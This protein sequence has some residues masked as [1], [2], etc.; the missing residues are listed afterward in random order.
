[1]AAT[2]RNDACPGCSSKLR[3]IRTQDAASHL[4]GG[5]GGEKLVHLVAEALV[6]GP[7]AVEEGA[8][9]HEAADDGVVR[10]GASLCLEQE[11]EDQ[12]DAVVQQQQVLGL[13]IGD[14][15][16]CRQL[17]RPHLLQPP[18]LNL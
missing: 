16:R 9:L 2:C 11:V 15:L 12:M 18:S 6:D 17:P 5:G 1:M 8:D 13:Q 4:D 3:D 7:R 14:T 10:H